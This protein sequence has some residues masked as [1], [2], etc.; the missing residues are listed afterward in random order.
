MSEPAAALKALAVAAGV[1]RLFWIDDQFGRSTKLVGRAISTKIEILWRLDRNAQS[2]H[3]SLKNL[4]VGSDPEAV[5]SYVLNILKESKHQ[6]TLSEEPVSSLDERS[7]EDPNH[8]P[9]IRD[10]SFTQFAEIQTA[11]RDAGVIVEILSYNQWLDGKRKSML[12]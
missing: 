7:R 6:D 10:L 5:E 8:K 3:A 11:F 9:D 1:E 12:T 4:P 2:N